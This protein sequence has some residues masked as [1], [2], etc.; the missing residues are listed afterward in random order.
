MNNIFFSA[1]KAQVLR[2]SVMGFMV[3]YAIVVS[4]HLLKELRLCLVD[5][6][7]QTW[8]VIMRARCINNNY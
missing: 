1:N 4:I 5:I 6:I 7:T 3:K 8:T 2:F